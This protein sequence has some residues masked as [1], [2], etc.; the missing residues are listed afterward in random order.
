MWLFVAAATLQQAKEPSKL[1]EEALAHLDNTQNNLG[2]SFADIKEHLHKVW[3]DTNASL[4]K[5]R[6]HVGKPQDSFLQMH[7]DHMAAAGHSQVHDLFA[8]MRHDLVHIQQLTQRDLAR[9]AAL[10]A[11]VAP[12]TSLLENG[13]VAETYS[14]IGDHLQK[15]WSS[16]NASIAELRA[17][18]EK[19]APESLLETP[20]G[21]TSM[22]ARFQALKDTLHQLQVKENAQIAEHARAQPSSLLETGAAVETFSDIGKHLQKVWL[23]TNASLAEI[24]QHVA[25]RP[26]SLLETPRQSKMHGLFSGLKERLSKLQVHADHELTALKERQLR[27]KAL[28]EK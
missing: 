14:E 4:A 2:E 5:M 25:E 12:P 9:A 21:H 1:V 16:A 22:H 13:A 28:G 24:R 8:A 20:T 3:A 19:N 15:I 18:A 7:P 10:K 6:A 27:A 23:N 17:D 11:K 26:A